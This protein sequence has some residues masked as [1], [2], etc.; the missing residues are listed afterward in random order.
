M[1]LW[2]TSCQGE[3]HRVGKGGE[4]GRGRSGER[5]GAAN[6]DGTGQGTSKGES[7]R[8]EEGNGYQKRK[9]SVGGERVGVTVVLRVE[10]CRLDS[11][12]TTSRTGATGDWSRNC[13]GCPRPTWTWEYCRRPSAL[14]AST[15]ARR[16][17]ALSSLR[18]RRDDTAVEWQ[19]STGRHHIFRLR[20]CDSLVPT[21][22][23]SSW[24]RG[25]GG[26]T[27]L[28]SNSPQRHLDDR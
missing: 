14:T 6:G 10:G 18:T 19:F 21:F 22:L 24:R 13:R 12:L 26:G 4:R 27:S 3:R 20:P 28:D 16:M 5:R 11:A 2:S 1:V 15:P 23:A 17:G 8:S 7:G 9:V 25:R